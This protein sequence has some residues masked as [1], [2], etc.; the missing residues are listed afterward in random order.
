MKSEIDYI[1]KYEAEK[2]LI[3]VALSRWE[4]LLEK[5]GHAQSSNMNKGFIIWMG[6]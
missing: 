5:A 1:A 3:K 2:V 6:F 4:S